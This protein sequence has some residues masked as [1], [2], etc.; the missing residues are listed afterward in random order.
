MPPL[1]RVHNRIA[2]AS[3]RPE[4]GCRA[5]AQTEHAGGSNAVETQRDR[6]GNGR[7]VPCELSAVQRRRMPMCMQSQLVV[8]E[9]VGVR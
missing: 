6:T 5:D 4:R 7:S 8:I 1:V 2:Q 3:A 9:S